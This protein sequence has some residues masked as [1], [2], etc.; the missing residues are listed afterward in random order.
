M[1]IIK[2]DKSIE[3]N[4]NQMFDYL[5]IIADPLRILALSERLSKRFWGS[6]SGQQIRSDF[7]QDLSS[8]MS[9]A[10]G[11]IWFLCRKNLFMFLSIPWHC[12]EEN[13][14]LL[15]KGWNLVWIS[16]R[17]LGTKACY[18]WVLRQWLVLNTSQIPKSRIGF[19]QYSW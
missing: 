8:P 16:R 7:V 13:C 10:V 5:L 15:F 1:C 6:L 19:G 18:S 4:K 3:S 11:T 14:A 9:R 12:G 17:L 2:P